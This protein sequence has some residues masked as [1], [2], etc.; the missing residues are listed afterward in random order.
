MKK[1]KFTVGELINVLKK[2]D[3]ETPVCWTDID[4][5]YDKSKIEMLSST[6]ETVLEKH[7]DFTDDFGEKRYG[8]Y[9]SI[10]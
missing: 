4:F 2:Y 9:I 8:K 10:Q 5:D 6:I 1:I 7:G 3:P